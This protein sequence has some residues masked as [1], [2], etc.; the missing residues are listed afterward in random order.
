MLVGLCGSLNTEAKY[1]PFISLN[2]DEVQQMLLELSR[3]PLSKP[4]LLEKYPELGE[5][6]EH[7]LRL[8]ALKQNSDSLLVNFTLFN[9][10]DLELIYDVTRNYAQ[11]LATLIAKEKGYINEVLAQYSN[12]KINL[13]KLAFIIVGCYFLD[14]GSLQLM[15]SWDM[16]EVGKEQ[17]GKSKYTLWA[18]EM[19]IINKKEIYS[20]GHSAKIG[21]YLYH[22]FG[23]HAVDT[24]RNAFPDLLFYSDK[25]DKLASREYNRLLSDKKDELAKE[26]GEIIE[27]IGKTGVSK[28]KLTATA[29]FD[30]TKIEK[31]VDLLKELDY[32][33]EEKNSLILNIPYF[34]DNDMELLTEIISHLVPILYDWAKDNLE[35]IEK[36]IES[37]SAI[38]NGV[39]FKEVFNHTWHFIFGLTNKY[40]VQENL[41]YDT[42]SEDSIHKGYLP[43]VVKGDLLDKV[44]ERIK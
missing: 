37:V 8:N 2:K 17:P 21:T 5:D 14:W 38:Q 28:D 16:M 22:T 39:P 34:D 20:G 7:L 33:S 1:N 32:I 42:Y 43:A 12:Q 13:K 24:E 25:Y 31:V 9:K 27:I 29:D 15:K 35:E 4:E 44:N 11:N 40:L 3:K 18:E 23:D 26:I 41:I 6:I 30:R 19:N 36:S 10:E